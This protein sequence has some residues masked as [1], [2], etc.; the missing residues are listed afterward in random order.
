LPIAFWVSKWYNNNVKR[1]RKPPLQRLEN[2][3]QSDEENSQKKVFKN[4]L[5][6]SLKYGI[7]RYTK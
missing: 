5:T 4:L 3:P 7:I 1:G 2:N 6:N